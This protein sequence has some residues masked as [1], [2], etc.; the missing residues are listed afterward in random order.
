MALAAACRCACIFRTVVIRRGSLLVL[1][2]L[3]RRRRELD[4]VFATGGLLAASDLVLGWVLQNQA[5]FANDY[6][7]NQ[8]ARAEDHVHAG[9][10]PETANE[11]AS[12]A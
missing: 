7:H 12:R 8:L 2:G 9:E 11:N 3:L 10:V 4:I 1:G 6:V 5:N